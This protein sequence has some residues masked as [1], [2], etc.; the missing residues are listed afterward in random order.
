MITG[1]LSTLGWFLVVWWVLT[2]FTKKTI[3]QEIHGGVP[4]VGVP[5]HV[6]AGGVIPPS[7][8]WERLDQQVLIDAINKEARTRVALETYMLVAGASEEM[9]KEMMDLL[10]DPRFQPK[11]REKA[12]PR[13]PDGE[14]K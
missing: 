5:P 10:D 14:A 8:Q 2:R 9:I 6:Q 3:K 13:N 11:P 12:K 7:S 1:V 4:P